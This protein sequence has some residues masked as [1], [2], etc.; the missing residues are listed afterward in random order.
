MVD[1]IGLL[2]AMDGQTDRRTD[3]QISTIR[4]PELSDEID[5]FSKLERHDRHRESVELDGRTKKTDGLID[6][7]N[8]YTG[9]TPQSGHN[10]V[11]GPRSCN[12]SLN[13][14][15]SYCFIPFFS[16]IVLTNNLPMGMYM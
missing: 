8:S 10:I 9:V 7:N 2:N 4:T 16:I 15:P 3:G 6:Y 12:S 14:N 13:V 11:Y 5:N 1:I